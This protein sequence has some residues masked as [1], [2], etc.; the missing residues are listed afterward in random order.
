ML[1]SASESACECD[2]ST[3]SKANK[4]KFMHSNYKP[5]KNERKIKCQATEGSSG[6]IL[7]PGNALKKFC[8]R[9]K[10]WKKKTNEII[11]IYNGN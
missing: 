3:F 4:Q 6:A 10:K 7:V 11:V 8:Q 5:C 1:E 2:V 9:A